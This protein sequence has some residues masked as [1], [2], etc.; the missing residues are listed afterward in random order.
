M[1][2]GGL[3]HLVFCAKNLKK[4]IHFRFEYFKYYL[5][6]ARHRTV[7]YYYPFNTNYC[8]AFNKK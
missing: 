1:A 5:Y 6:L 7:D 4:K 8:F 2:A 3:D